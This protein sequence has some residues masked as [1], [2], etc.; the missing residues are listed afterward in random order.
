MS[1]KLKPWADRYLTLRGSLYPTDPDGTDSDDNNSDG[2]ESNDTD[3][4][5]TKKV[6]KPVGATS[7]PSPRILLGEFLFTSE[8]SS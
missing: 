4:E 8:S 7:L 2:N 5:C 6:R 1:F 3:S